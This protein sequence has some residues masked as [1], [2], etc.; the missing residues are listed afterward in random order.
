MQTKYRLLREAAYE[1]GLD[2]YLHLSEI[3]SFRDFLVLFITEGHRRSKHAVAI[4]NSDPA[5]VRLAVRWMRV[6]SSQ[7]LRY[8]IQYHAD[9]KLHELREFWASQLG[10][11]GDEIRL[12]R[13]S[14]SGQLAGRSWRSRYGVL[15]VSAGDTY[16]REAMQAWTDCLRDTWLNSTPVGA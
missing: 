11:S 15:T 5:V 6:F 1:E 3:P 4:A 7:G 13:K 2:F 16:F 12:Q 9:Q 10:V 8:S 14:N